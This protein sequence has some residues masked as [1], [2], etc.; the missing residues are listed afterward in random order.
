[1]GGLRAFARRI[2]AE[3]NLYGALA[4]AETAESLTLIR[5]AL[6]PVEGARIA[7]ITS[8]G[9]VLLMLAAQGAA[10]IAGFDMNPAQTALAELKRTAASSL[11]VA[12]YR[13]FLGI[14]PAPAHERKILF[15]RVGRREARAVFA[16]DAIEAGLVNR[17]MT[18]LIIH[19]LAALLAKTVAPETMA[20]FLGE[21]GTDA[22]RARALDRL[23]Q[24]SVV[25]RGFAPALEAAAPQLKWLF[26]P[27]TLCRVSTRPDAMI[28]RFFETFRPLFVGGAKKNPVLSRSA[29]GVLHP[30][31]DAELLSEARFAAIA[32]MGDRL[33][34]ET[35]AITGGLAALPPRW[36]NRIYLSN[37]PDYLTDAE[38]A[39]LGRAI[40][41]AAAPGARVL[42]FS[43]TDED[44]LAR[45]L[46]PLSPDIEDV[47]ALDH[48]FLYPSIVV[49]NAVRN[50]GET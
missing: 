49:R 35:R 27:H 28:A 50:A 12:T 22:D 33:R 10:E 24:R 36:A 44:R 34:F 38:L 41:H 2:V 3:R 6:A 14:D 40:A 7:G 48:V 15:D 46:G 8:S 17:G 43:L 5:R 18:H 9:D 25:K 19:G 37:A 29:T 39:A 45:H 42:Y 23:L 4:F 26:F 13:R 20:L 32:K 21:G 11:D 1:V 16:P 30:D 47:R 31:W